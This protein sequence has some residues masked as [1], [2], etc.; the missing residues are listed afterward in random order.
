MSRSRAGY[1]DIQPKYQEALNDRGWFE[2]EMTE[3]LSREDD[4]CQR[5]DARTV[6]LPTGPERESCC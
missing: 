2:N 6:E 1:W 3:S 4:L 5:F